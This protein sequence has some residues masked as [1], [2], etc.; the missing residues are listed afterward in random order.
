MFWDVKEILTNEK[1]KT[2]VMKLICDKIDLNE[3]I[4]NIIIKKLMNSIL[5]GNEEAVNNIREIYSTASSH[6]I[7][8][9]IE[10]HFIPTN[11]EKKNNAEVP[12]PVVLVDEMLNPYFYLIESNFYTKKHLLLLG[13]IKDDI[14]NSYFMFLI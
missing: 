3:E 5:D 13:R 1:T 11:E 4:Y 12:T 10:K 9:L 7:R 6:K 2:L 14:Y 8:G